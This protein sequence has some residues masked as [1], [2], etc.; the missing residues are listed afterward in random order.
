MRIVGWTYEADV[1]CPACAVHRFGYDSLY[2]DEGA[3]DSEGN[4]V[5]PIFSTD[6]LYDDERCGDCLVEIG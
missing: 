3:V 6:E 1:H 5:H 4:E 2:G